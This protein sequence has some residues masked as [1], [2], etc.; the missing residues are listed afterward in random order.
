MIKYKLLVIDDEVSTRDKIYDN[1]LKS[2]ENFD[3][4]FI[5]N[6]DD[7]EKIIN[8]TK[9]DGYIVDVVL[10]NWHLNLKDVL[11]II[12]EK[13]PIILVIQTVINNCAYKKIVLAWLPERREPCENYKYKM[14]T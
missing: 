8:T 3:L 11:D 9:V 1:V 4:L 6:V 14:L 2:S 7:V 5:R 12:L 13:G 10:E